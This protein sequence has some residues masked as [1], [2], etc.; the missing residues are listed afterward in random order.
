MIPH[1]CPVCDGTGLVSKPPWIAG[2]VNSWTDSG[3][4]P[5]VCQSCDGKRIIWSNPSE[6]TWTPQETW[7]GGEGAD[8]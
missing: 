1:K 8:L 5:Y 3:T 6:Q 4:A 2:D 7:M